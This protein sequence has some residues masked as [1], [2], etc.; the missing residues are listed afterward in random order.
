[1]S[2]HETRRNNPEVVVVIPT[3]NE[4]AGIGWVLDRT[5]ETLRKLGKPYH[6]IV[7]DGGSQ[8]RTVE[9]TRIQI[10]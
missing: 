7:V 9:I 8:D 2:S 5:H 3:L 1:M 6:I 4:E 10:W